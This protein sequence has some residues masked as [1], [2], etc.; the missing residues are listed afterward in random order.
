[1]KQIVY[2]MIGLLS[3]FV[4]AGALFFV[5][6]APSGK[7]VTLMPS[8]TKEPIQVHVI[9]AV[10]RPG[11]YAFTEGSRVQDAINAAGGLLAEAD[12][13]SINLAAKLEDGQQL[14]VP[15]GEGAAPSSSSNAPFTVLSTPGA[16]T[17]TQDLLNIN[18]AS[19]EDLDSL[20]GIGPTTAQKI[21]DYRD[22]HGPFEHIEDIMNVAGIGPATFD[23]I[24]DLIAV[25]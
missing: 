25:E 21:V 15:F 3:G 22:Q 14:D 1:M 19:A 12:P 7:A 20:P 17:S 18:T 4:L 24:K 9:G 5:A 16:S 23:N 10:V 13:N 8:P 2:V 6:R 11:V